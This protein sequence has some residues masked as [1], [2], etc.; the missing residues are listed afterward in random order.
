MPI[1]IDKSFEM[2]K[3]H[4]LNNHLDKLWFHTQLHCTQFRINKFHFDKHHDH[5]NCWGMFLNYNLFQTNH[6]DIG[7]F[8]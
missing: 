6:F 1:D 2:Y 4:F 7:M 5:Y 8:H 3:F